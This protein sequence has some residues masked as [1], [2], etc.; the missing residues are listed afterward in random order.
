MLHV[1][2]PPPYSHAKDR[3]ESSTKAIYVV[4]LYYSLKSL[5]EGNKK[6]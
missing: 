4:A 6:Y 5:G 2:L 3:A 1:S